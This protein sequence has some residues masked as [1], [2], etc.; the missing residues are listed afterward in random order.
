MSASPGMTR[1]RP[2]TISDESSRTGTASRR[3]RITYFCTA[4]SCPLLSGSPLLVHPGPRQ[5]RRAVTVCPAQCAGGHVAH[6]GLEDQE[7]VVVR[8]PQPQRLI[9]FTIDDLLGQRTLF[10]LVR[11]L[12]ELRRQLIDDGI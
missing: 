6:V 3:R 8:H 10:G 11:R 7:A 4:V 9:E 1:I 12:S 2:K 5:G